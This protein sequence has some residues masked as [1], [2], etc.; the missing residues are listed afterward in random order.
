M[1]MHIQFVNIA[2]SNSL[3]T[4]IEEKLEN[5]AEKYSNITKAAVY[6]KK[7]NTSK[8]DGKICEMELSVPGP[9]IFASSNETNYELA[10]KN[11]ISDLEKQL[12]KKKEAT[13]PY[14]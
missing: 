5:L 7:E 1:E 14:V 13:K 2:V 12:R 10:V 6:V 9:R 4:Y 3:E 11:T 8:D